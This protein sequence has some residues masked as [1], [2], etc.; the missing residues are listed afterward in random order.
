MV[1]K[2]TRAAPLTATEAEISA[3]W[4]GRSLRQTERLGV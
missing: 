2:D 1:L 4:P 3:H